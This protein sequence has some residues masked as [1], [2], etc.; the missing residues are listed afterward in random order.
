[1]IGMVVVIGKRRKIIEVSVPSPARIFYLKYAR[2]T[3]HLYENMILTSDEY[4][5]FETSCVTI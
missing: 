3:W 5:K 4:Y 2:A 1:M